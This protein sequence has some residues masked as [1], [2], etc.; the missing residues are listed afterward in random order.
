MIE[1]KHLFDVDVIQSSAVCVL[2]SFT[3]LVVHEYSEIQQNVH[4]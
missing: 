3:L 4:G 1:N 2:F